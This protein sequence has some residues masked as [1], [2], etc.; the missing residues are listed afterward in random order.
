MEK[1]L[2][3][4]IVNAVALKGE[5]KVYTYSNPQRYEE[6][7]EIYVENEPHRIEKVRFQGNTVI[8]K[9][10]GIDDRNAA[11]ACKG[12]NVYIEESE[13]PE[14][15]EDTYYIRDLIGMKVVGDD[16]EIIGALSDVLQN[17]AQDVYEVKSESGKNVLIPGV[18]EFILD[19]DINERKITVR[20]PEGLLEL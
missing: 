17:T 20:L 10:T 12:K 11:E 18:S 7:N 3:G 15:P 13:L 9:L 16:G 2:I 8:L 5:V 4:K 19:I 6:I 14:L 1:I